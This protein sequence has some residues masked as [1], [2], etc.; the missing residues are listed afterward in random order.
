MPARHLKGKHSMLGR[1]Q[2]LICVCLKFPRENAEVGHG[3]GP[4]VEAMGEDP[5]WRP[6]ARTLCGGQGHSDL[7]PN[8]VFYTANICEW[9]NHVQWSIHGWIEANKL[10]KIDQCDWRRSHEWP[11]KGITGRVVYL[12][13]LNEWLSQIWR[14][15]TEYEK[16]RRQKKLSNNAQSFTI[17]IKTTL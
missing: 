11:N 3:R 8:E 17:T 7:A 12:F 6:W 16:K 10:L 2:L 15:V 9:P 5:M 4:Y 13:K 1:G 14:Y